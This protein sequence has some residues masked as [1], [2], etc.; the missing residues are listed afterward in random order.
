MIW[1]DNLRIAVGGATSNKLRSLLTM[2]GV[3][4]GVASVII[5]VA[6]GTGSSQ[7]VQKNIA[8]LGTNTLTV[9]T[10]GRFG[11]RATTGTQTKAATITLS[12]VSAIQDPSQ[13]PD[14][15]SVSPVVSTSVTATFNGATDTSATVT[16]STPSYLTAINDTV[17]AGSSITSS[18][19]TN[20]S[21]VVVIGQTVVSDLFANQNPIGQTIEL[22]SS[23]FQIV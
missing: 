14:V 2:L 18:E 23:G 16:G 6:V 21:R 4:I 12:D 5:L 8:R 15:A 20:R 10:S 11:G 22:G 9:L 17:Q 1:R 3:L 19:M 13:A 7:S